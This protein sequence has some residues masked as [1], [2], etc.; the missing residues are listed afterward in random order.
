MEKG[1]CFCCAKPVKITEPN[2]YANTPK[3]APSYNESEPKLEGRVTRQKI[4]RTDDLPKRYAIS[5]ARMWS[6][7]PASR[8]RWAWTSQ[9]SCRRKRKNRIRSILQPSNNTYR[10]KLARSTRQSQSVGLFSFGNSRFSFALAPDGRVQKQDA[11][12]NATPS[13]KLTNRNGL[14][15][16][17]SPDH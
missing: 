15:V 4:E 14:A 2:S 10:L 7:A 12:K 1:A 5:P 13:G 3:E 16:K 9:D 6:S 8:R 11:Q 17:Y